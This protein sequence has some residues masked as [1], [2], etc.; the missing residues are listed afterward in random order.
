MRKPKQVPGSSGVYAIVREETDEPAFLE[1]SG[2]GW[3]KGKDPTVTHDKL[4]A[5]WVDGT[6]TVYIGKADSLRSRLDL[7]IGFS[8]GEAIMH[9]GGRYLWQLEGCERL[10]VAWRVEPEFAGTETDLIDEFIDTYGR[11]PFANLKRGDRR[12][13]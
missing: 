13:L 7:L 11:L 3:W 2:G 10:L 9:W 4:L 6:P 8:R 1:R 5:K 12:L